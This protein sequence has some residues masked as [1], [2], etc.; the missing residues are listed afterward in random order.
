M[1]SATL[2]YVFLHEPAVAATRA[3]T[4]SAFSNAL[5]V[6]SI[7]WTTAIRLVLYG[8]EE[9]LADL[10]LRL[11]VS[12]LRSDGDKDRARI[13]FEFGDR[14][15]RE[16]VLKEGRLQ[17]DEPSLRQL[18]FDCPSG[19]RDSPVDV[20]LSEIV[21]DGRGRNGHGAQ[22]ATPL[23]GSGFAQRLR[24]RTAPPQLQP[25]TNSREASTESCVFRKT[26]AASASLICAS[27]VVSSRLPSLSPKPRKSMR[28]LANPLAAEA[29]A[30][31][32]KIPSFTDGIVSFVAFARESMQQ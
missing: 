10:R 25:T 20:V 32:A 3:S 5:K 28:R 18:R 30:A 11:H 31:R 9:D 14:V 4:V 15:E 24:P 13:P 19:A 7:G 2:F 21:R 12:V 26:I 17:R 6:W 29:L 1:L 16:E 23:I 8:R 27:I 22:R